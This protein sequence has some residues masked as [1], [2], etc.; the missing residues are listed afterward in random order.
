MRDHPLRPVL[1]YTGGADLYR[2]RSSSAWAT[3]ATTSHLPGAATCTASDVVVRPPCAHTRHFSSSITSC[4]LPTAGH[5]FLLVS[6][7]DW[8]DHP[9]AGQNRRTLDHLHHR[10]GRHPAVLVVPTT[11]LMSLLLVGDT[12]LS[13]K[14]RSKTT[15]HNILPK[16]ISCTVGAY[17]VN[18][19]TQIANNRTIDELLFEKE[20][21][22]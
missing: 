17:S 15:L 10:S 1:G 22:S 12:C 18:W 20:K 3:A 19:C 13:S 16:Q 9:R 11:N 6:I 7:Q 8:F 2:D 5:R 21:K 14:F 4:A